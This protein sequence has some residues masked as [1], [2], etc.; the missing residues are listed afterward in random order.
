MQTGGIRVLEELSAKGRV[1]GVKQTL[2][3]IREGRAASVFLAADA[4]D[5]ILTPL[6]TACQET[7]TPMDASL[8]RKEL[9][10]QC[11]IEVGTAAAAVLKK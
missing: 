10:R 8:S 3:A 6:K 9:G 7:Q 1:V 2:R 5:R 11:G 4:E